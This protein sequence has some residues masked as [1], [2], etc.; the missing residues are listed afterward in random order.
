[1]AGAPML[2]R[3][4]ER[5]QSADRLDR[6]AIATS[7]DTADDEIEN[8]C[9]GLGLPCFRGSEDD[10]LD[11]VWRAAQALE[12]RTLVRLTGDNPLLNGELVD[13]LV[14]AFVSADPPAAW[15]ISC[16]EAGFPNGLTAEVVSMEAL[17]EALASDDP[18]D[19]EHVTWF[20]RSRPERFRQL[21][22]LAPHRF[23]RARLTVDTEDDYASVRSLFEGLYEADRNFG[24]ADIAAALS[25]RSS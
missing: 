19:R 3:L 4:M 25:R 13:W 18:A 15:A 20:V 12:A 11:R 23:P 16:E 1:M 17:E 2:Q 24:M 8:L 10:V 21:R 6:L 14:D 5:L 22:P 7:T 9:D